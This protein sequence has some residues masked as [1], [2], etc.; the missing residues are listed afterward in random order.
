[1]PVFIYMQEG[2]STVV[3]LPFGFQMEGVLIVVVLCQI[4]SGIIKIMILCIKT[5]HKFYV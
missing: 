1:M 2:E 3:K 5:C 4:I